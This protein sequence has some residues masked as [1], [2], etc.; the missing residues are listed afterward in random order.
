LTN[1]FDLTTFQIICIYAYR[2]QIELLF[3]FLKRTMN[4]L[5]LIKNDKR[6]VMIQFYALLI[7]AI[8]GR[9]LKQDVLQEI[10]N[11]QT[12]TLPITRSSSFYSI[13]FCINKNEHE[14]RFYF[15]TK[16]K[17][18]QPFPLKNSRILKIISLRIGFLVKALV[19][20]CLNFCQLSVF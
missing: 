10:E 18:S 19:L 2:W 12:R 1:R 20:I 3:R 11:R 17:N 14:E 8:L 16:N 15:E 6:G 9:N 4:G 7:T 13:I 5:H